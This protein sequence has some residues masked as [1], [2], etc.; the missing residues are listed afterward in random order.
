MTRLRLGITMILLALAIFFVLGAAAVRS[1]FA[2]L[3]NASKENVF[4]SAAQLEREIAG[5]QVVL[6][7]HLADPEVSARTV[8]RSFDLLWSRVGL[9]Q[10]GEIG[11][12]MMSSPEVSTAIEKLS[13]TLRRADPL[14]A[15]VGTDPDDRAE[16]QS[17][18]ADLRNH[19]GDVRRISVE[20][21][22]LDHALLASVRQQMRRSILLTA[23][24]GFLM[25]AVTS[26]LLFYFYRSALAN[27]ALAR[28]VEAAS[29]ARQR[30][31]A[32]VSHELR[33]PLNGVQ[34][35][36]A[37]LREEPD[38]AMRRVYME[39]AE[40]S[41]ERLSGLLTDAIELS[42]EEPTDV[43]ETVFRLDEVAGALRVALQNELRRSGTQLTIEC[44][45][46]ALVFLRGDLRRIAQIA[47]HM[48]QS[49]LRSAEPQTVNAQISFAQRMLRIELEISGTGEFP[50]PLGLDMLRALT[51][52]LD[53]KLE[54]DGPTARIQ[55]P[56]SVRHLT[57]G[58]VFGSTALQSLYRRLLEAEGI[59]VVSLD[60]GIS[61][62]P[63]DLVLCDRNA[64]P[65]EVE[66][67]RRAYPD[68]RMIGCGAG[69][70]VAFGF[71]AVSA[72]ATD[73][74]AA[75]LRAIRSPR[76]DLPL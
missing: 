68:A 65:E 45:R 42:A 12:R 39:Q 43:T 56:L 70:G 15:Q 5:F 54:L 41:S 34:G 6:A 9:F 31:F 37:L 74:L 57:V 26:S 33:T 46:G 50:A 59:E 51:A 61:R 49:A 3:Q 8:K 38:R 17:L 36:L 66:R 60:T 13:T 25:L 58:A 62:R 11:A 67:L 53:G 40:Q 21:L 24:A 35:A 14:I 73:I 23:L 47:S 28:D 1:D 55:V 29:Q 76:P 7:N 72:T 44:T 48:L 27:A 63:V 32:H 2:A 4:W 52:K 64:P 18:A 69:S 22:H 10:E 16:L 30:F 19:A 71:D 20:V 75:V